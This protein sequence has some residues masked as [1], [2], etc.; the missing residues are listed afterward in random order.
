MISLIAS[1]I[2]LDF[3]GESAQQKGLG[4]PSPLRV[5]DQGRVKVYKRGASKANSHL[6][7][8]GEVREG[9]EARED[10]ERHA[11]VEPARVAAVACAHTH[12]HSLTH[13]HTQS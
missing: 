1:S 10:V 4:H 12:T 13:T 6:E 3:D 5:R 2:S 7:F 8:V 11:H 9:A